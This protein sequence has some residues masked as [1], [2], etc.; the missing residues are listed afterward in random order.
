MAGRLPLLRPGVHVCLTCADVCWNP[1]LIVCCALGCAAFVV[2]SN[3]LLSGLSME[4][5]SSSRAQGLLNDVG[6]HFCIGGSDAYSL[7]LLLLVGHEGQAVARR[8]LGPGASSAD[9]L[10]WFKSAA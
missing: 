9:V 7:C 4:S 1:F 5:A 3:A 10:F 8:R 6:L 2:I